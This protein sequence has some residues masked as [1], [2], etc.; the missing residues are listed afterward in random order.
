MAQS[1]ARA[2]ALMRSWPISAVSLA[3]PIWNGKKASRRD[4]LPFKRMKVRLKREIVTMGIEGI[5][6]NHTVGTYVAPE[7]W[8]DLISMPDIVVVDTRNDYEFAIG[9]FE[10]ALKSTKHSHSGN[11]PAG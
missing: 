4:S 11:F 6:P 1:P 2:R 8:N 3:A 5:D 10:G 9:S 7:D